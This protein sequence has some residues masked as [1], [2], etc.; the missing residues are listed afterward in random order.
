MHSWREWCLLLFL[1]LLLF[2]FYN[3]FNDVSWWLLLLLPIFLNFKRP[4]PLEM[5]TFIVVSE[6]RC[7]W[8]G[9]ACYHTR[10]CFFKWCDVTLNFCF[11]RIWS[12]HVRHLINWVLEN[13]FNHALKNYIRWIQ[14]SIQH[15]FFIHTW[16]T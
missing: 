14:S 3:D 11:R 8:V 5:F 16:N 15:H 9:S 13:K 1:L 10:W 7:N 6:K 2:E 4:I 12:Y